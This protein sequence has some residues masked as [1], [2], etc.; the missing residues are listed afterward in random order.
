MDAD[1]DLG[2][3]EEGVGQQNNRKRCRKRG[4]PDPSA[5]VA[6]KHELES[7]LKGDLFRY[8]EVEPNDYGLSTE[9]VQ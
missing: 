4:N 9:E 6:E 8:R 5:K 1:Y 7:R 3:A 2:Y